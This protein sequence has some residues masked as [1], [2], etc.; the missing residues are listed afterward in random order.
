MENPNHLNEPN[1]VIPEMN[2]VV[3][4]PNQ[5]VDIHD[6]NEMVDIPDDI[7]VAPEATVRTSTQNPYAIRDFPRGLYEVGE[8]SSSRDSSYV[9]GL[10]P[11]ALRRDLEASHAQARVMEAELG[12]CQT[13]IALIKS[14]NKIREKEKEL[15][16]HDLENVERALGNV[17]ERVS[18]LESGENATVKKRLDETETKL[19]W[20][21]MERDTAERRLHES[22]VWNK[23]FYLDMVRIGAV[24]KPPSDDEDTEHQRK[25]SKNS[26][27]DGTEG[28]SEPRGIF[29]KSLT[30]LRC[31]IMPPKA[32]SE[33]RMREVIREQVA[34]SMAEFVANINRRAGGGGAGGG[35]A[36][37]GGAGGAE[38]SGVGPTTPKITGC[39]YVTFM[40]CNPQPFKG[41]KDAMGLCQWFKKLE[42]VFRISDCKERDK[43]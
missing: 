43:V 20:A 6:P 9:D 17:L 10:A 29:C 26:T 2:P 37:G 28:P 38:A 12:T 39:T 35:G 33:A 16:N 42:S 22:R 14:K 41:T 31:L 5:V 15:L 1:R 34:A 24:P 19:V 36:G 30:K 21:C 4:E 23:R 7:D 13:K 27:S 25:K 3:P 32:M 11:W 8:S 40:K 18:I